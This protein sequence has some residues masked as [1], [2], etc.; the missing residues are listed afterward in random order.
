MDLLEGDFGRRRE[1]GESVSDDGL[2]VGE[3][4]IVARFADLSPCA[5]DRS[6]GQAEVCL[7]SRG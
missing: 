4:M 7:V 2:A 3:G 6:D 5:Y 1:E